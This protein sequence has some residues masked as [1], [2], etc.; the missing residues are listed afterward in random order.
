MLHVGAHELVRRQSSHKGQLS[1]QSGAGHDSEKR[2]PQK[3]R[4]G[5]GSG[6]GGGGGRLECKERA[7]A[8]VSDWKRG[9]SKMPRALQTFYEVLR[10]IIVK[11]AEGVLWFFPDFL[12]GAEIYPP[13]PLNPRFEMCVHPS[14]S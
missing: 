8:S 4:H 9:N 2:R 7:G 1:R 13:P 11:F 14:V 6:M 10:S 5:S 12:G 3:K